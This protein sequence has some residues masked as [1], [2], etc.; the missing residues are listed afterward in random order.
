MLENLL[1]LLVVAAILIISG[2]ITQLFANRMYRRCSDC[3]TLN[4]KR[5]SVCRE[6]GQPLHA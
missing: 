1:G 4:A 2:L 6:C 5:R 3:G